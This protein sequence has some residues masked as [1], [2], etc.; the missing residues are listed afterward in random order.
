MREKVKIFSRLPP[1]HQAAY[2]AQLTDAEERQALKELMQVEHA[3]KVAQDLESE[4]HGL[5]E[6]QA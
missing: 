5:K 2:L 6:K 1:E 4:L 3:Q